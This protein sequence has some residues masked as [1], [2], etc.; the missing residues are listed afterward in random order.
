MV[1]V[2]QLLTRTHNQVITPIKPPLLTGF[3][4][5]GNPTTGLDSPA[6]ASAA[7]RLLLRH[8]LKERIAHCY[9]IAFGGGDLLQAFLSANWDSDFASLVDV[10]MR[11][12][13]A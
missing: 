11:V 9:S 10:R 5:H 4:P 12:L 13:S 8:V 6:K 1:I 3:R 2:M 7:L